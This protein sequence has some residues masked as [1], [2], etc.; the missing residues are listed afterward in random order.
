MLHRTICL[1]I[2]FAV[3]FYLGGCSTPG[4]G[5]PRYK[6]M[7]TEMDPRVEF[8]KDS[9]FMLLGD[10]CYNILSINQKNDH[11][12]LKKQFLRRGYKTFEFRQKPEYV[13]HINFSDHMKY[14]ELKE[15]GL[16]R[17]P[18]PACLNITVWDYKGFPDKKNLIWT[19]QIIDRSE[20]INSNLEFCIS[21]MLDHFGENYSSD[22]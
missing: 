15:L 13:V 14:S 21:S 7:T 18:Q 19:G 22:R 4:S 16:Q 17:H 1:L 8:S 11:A 6:K 3:I 20:S 10:V 9:K 2:S 12:L 5:I